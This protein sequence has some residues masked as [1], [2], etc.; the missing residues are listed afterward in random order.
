MKRVLTIL[1]L[2]LGF[3]VF[4]MPAFAA[5]SDL[6]SY[7]TDTLNIITIIASAA[8]TLFL[9]KGGYL[10]FTSAGQPQALEEAKKTIRN[11][12]MGLVVVLAAGLIV[13]VFKGAL[14]AS[15]GDTSTA[16][17]AIAPIT[18]IKPTDGLSQVLIDAVSAFIQ[19]IVE[20]STKP[21]VDGIIG[22]L[23]TTPN[24]LGNSVITKF[25]LVSLGIVDTL[26]VLVVAL[27]GLHFMS[28]SALG[29]EEVELKQLLPRIGTAFLGANISLF[30][31]DYVITTC[32]VLVKTILDSTGGLTHAWIMDAINPVTFATGGTPLITL[33]FLVLFLILSVVL[34]LMYI[35]RL[36]T[37]SLGAVLSPFIFLLWTLPK[38]SDF[39]EIAIKSYVVTVFMVFVHVV[40]IQLAAAFLTIPGNSNNSLL[41]IAIAIGLFLTLLKVPG[42]MMQMV[43]YT[44]RNGTFKKMG[45]Q[46]VN[47]MT[48]DKSGA[49]S[50]ASSAA[51]EAV[52]KL[53]RKA[54][55]I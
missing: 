4:P 49:A 32:N 52:V 40:I 54:V 23:T 5:G 26:F 39:A 34:L 47:V 20:S 14:P 42:T 12:L 41:A 48:S 45:S 28:A 22:F 38:F 10:Y 1:G 51:R 55:A 9:I 11:S 3:F 37:L 44:S 17:V 6:A 36:I 15:T 46:I 33:I 16:A 25:W 8:A 53:P 31:A 43:F 24:L 29:F 27:L 35:A 13:S 2:V 21:I 7:T 18:T 30:L 19:N 50:S